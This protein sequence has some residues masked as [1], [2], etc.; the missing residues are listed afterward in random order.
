ML[1]LLLRTR[2]SAQLVS[3][4]GADLSRMQVLATASQ[5][6]EDSL[7]MSWMLS[8]RIQPLSPVAT[9]TA[10]SKNSRRKS[11]NSGPSA[12]E[13]ED[14][15]DHLPLLL[16]ICLDLVLA[17]CEAPPLKEVAVSLIR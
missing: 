6:A 2:T 1:R 4:A 12:G 11:A 16:P 17:G 8:S 3:A 15:Q 14:T 5:S 13:E 10:L 7:T 9:A